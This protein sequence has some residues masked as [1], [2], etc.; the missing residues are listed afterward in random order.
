MS[1]ELKDVIKKVTDSKAA[2]TV[3]ER[4]WDLNQRFL[5]GNQNI[6]YDRNLQSY[7]SNK[8]SSNVP[9][10]N[11]L[12]PLYRT[13]LSKLAASYPGVVV[14][15][16]SPSKEDIAKAQASEAA[17]RYYWKAEDIGS[18]INKVIEYLLIFGNAG[19]LSYYDPDKDKVCT[20]PINPFDIFYESG[21]AEIADARWVAIRQFYDKDDL[22][23]AYPEFTKE[24][25][26][27][28]E[29][30]GTAG[31]QQSNSY[32][33]SVDYIP[34][35]KVDVY[36]V[37][38]KNGKYGFLLN[39]T[40]IFESETPAKIFPFQH[41]KFT[42][43]PNRLWGLSML[44]PLIELQSYYNKARGQILQN[45]EMMANPKWLIPKN[46]GIAPNAITQRAGEKIFFSPA[47]GAP[48][49]VAGAPIPAYVI[50]NIR[51]LQSEIMDVAGIHS[52]TLG[53]RA[54]GVISGKA[55]E[56]LSGNDV[57]ALQTTQDAIERACSSMAS[58]VLVYMKEFYTEPKL[59]RMLDNT[60]RVIFHEVQKT[61]IVE[62]PEIHI[63]AGS[64]FHDKA[65]DREARV[66]SLFQ[67]GLL[68]PEE[69]LKELNYRT[70]NSF[71]IQQLEGSAHARDMLE[72]VR[73]GAGIEVFSTDDLQ[74]FQSV[75][76]EFMRSRDFY[77]LPKE[78]QDYI[79]DIL[80]SV[81]APT[82]AEGDAVAQQLR[83]NMK[84][85]PRVK[86][87]SLQQAQQSVA[88][89]A[90]PMAATQAA[91]GVVDQMG[92][93]NELNNM[94]NAESRVADTAPNEA[95]KMGGGV[96]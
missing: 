34:P 49:Q 36:E 33:N 88:S 47:G 46:S 81:A 8:G 40:F 95:L 62:D 55:I 93:Q 67:A 6:S 76:E 68:K 22:I 45:V 42:E 19:M 63:E 38:L 75:F 13:V 82:G 92:A 17:L 5:Q 85:F 31:L 7:T 20:K 70:G 84:V 59:Y 15:P 12:L 21:L 50:D 65:N 11:Q 3:E 4:T 27:A 73:L 79:R 30:S 71:I 78:R 56:A 74:A 1:F 9:V 29:S 14:L 89:Q 80:V 77:E 37:Y 86:A 39:E 58:T 35:G 24:I 60:G 54:V 64:L 16:A 43:I 66:M 28:K 61:N 25:E 51:Q 10:I 53:K 83:D 57:S 41:V 96:R 32:S 90:S 44:S 48:T 91:A 18:V 23:E 52:T 69:A 94:E 87:N 2:K 72:A 26:E